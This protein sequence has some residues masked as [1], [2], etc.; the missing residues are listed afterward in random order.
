MG[1]STWH[2][3]FICYDPSFNKFRVSRNIIFIENMYFFSL[4]WKKGQP[5]LDP[6][7]RPRRSKRGRTLLIKQV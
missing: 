2:K 7:D 6:Q 3:G 4:A 5:T 1:Y